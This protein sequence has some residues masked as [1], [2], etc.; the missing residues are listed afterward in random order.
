MQQT[1][2]DSQLNDNYDTK[3]IPTEIWHIV[4][5]Y[6]SVID[7]PANV[8]ALLHTCK[9][10]HDILMNH[11][12][13][14]ILLRIL[15]TTSTNESIELNEFFKSD[16]GIHISFRADIISKYR[17]NIT[18]LIRDKRVSSELQDYL[19]QMNKN[20]KLFEWLPFIETHGVEQI[21]DFYPYELFED[22]SFLLY[23]VIYLSIKIIPERFLRNIEFMCEA[24]KYNWECIHLIPQDIVGIYKEQLVLSGVGNGA[25][26]LKYFPDYCAQLD[27]MMKAAEKNGLVLKYASNELRNNKMFAT[28]AI[29]D[30][31]SALSYC[32]E[33]LLNEKEL[34]LLAVGQDGTTLQYASATLRNDPEVVLQAIKSSNCAVT[35]ASNDLRSDKSFALQAVKVNSRSYESFS[36]EVRANEKIL[37]EAMQE[38]PFALRYASADLR[39]NKQIVLDALAI[40]YQSVN[41]ASN[42]LLND[43]EFVTTLL[44]KEGSILEFVSD[45]LKSDRDVVLSAVRRNGEALKYAC[46][47]FWMDNSMVIEAVRQNR[48]LPETLPAYF[49]YFRIN[50]ED[51]MDNLDIL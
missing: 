39:N 1:N 20:L 41:Y 5:Q 43:K 33:E 38:N 13:E 15:R 6:M 10:F 8:F 4:F 28:V 30:T 49:E 18:E 37:R 21:K 9:T 32:S 3:W 47:E 17:M 45:N 22:P 34:V 27:F 35:F 50:L 46:E 2:D 36:E 16:R 7:S 44:Q 26:I 24:V 14:F 23:A 40:N 25:D 51:I 19:R 12:I 29:T 11:N 42:E 48:Q 31:A